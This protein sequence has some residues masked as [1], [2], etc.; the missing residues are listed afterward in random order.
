MEGSLSEVFDNT[1][2]D[3]IKETSI[4]RRDLQNNKSHT[5]TIHPKCC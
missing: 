5:V 3:E 1:K 4:L 2:T